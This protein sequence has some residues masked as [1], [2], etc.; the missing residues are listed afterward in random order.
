MK[1]LI[2][3]IV[4]TIFFSSCGFMEKKEMFEEQKQE[5]IEQNSD[6]V[7]NIGSISE[8]EFLVDG[9]Y[10]RKN[11]PARKNIEYNSTMVKSFL[12]TKSDIEYRIFIFGNGS[13]EAGIFIIN[14]TKDKLEIELLIKQLKSSDY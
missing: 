13:D 10:F 14:E 7:K 6:I 5:K 1:K 12:Y 3:I 2:Y 8:K 9:R 4:I 11:M